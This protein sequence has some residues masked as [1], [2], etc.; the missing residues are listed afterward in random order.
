MAIK[1]INGLVPEWF[2]PTSQQGDDNP[3]R[4][5]IRPLDGMQHMEVMMHVDVAGSGDL[6][7]DAK[8]M[9]LA[10][11]FGM[12]EWE[13]FTDDKGLPIPCTPDNYGKLP[14]NDLAEI[15]RTIINRSNLTE[16]ARKN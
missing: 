16:D 12:V 11:K 5:K 14:S 9:G 7:V 2:T 3:T 1:P 13:N 15:G 8:G 10:L 4:V 6:F